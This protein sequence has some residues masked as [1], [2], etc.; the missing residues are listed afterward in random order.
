V[1]IM[2]RKKNLGV[3][4]IIKIKLFVKKINQLITKITTIKSWGLGSLI[5]LFR[6][7]HALF[8]VDRKKDIIKFSFKK[9]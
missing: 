8:V 1:K 2:I 6:Y 4:S 7:H 9:I 5:K 3:I